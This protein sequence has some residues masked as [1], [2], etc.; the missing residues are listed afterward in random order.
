MTLL[1][2]SSYGTIWGERGG[3]RP[4]CP[5]RTGVVQKATAREKN[6]MGCIGQVHC[7]MDTTI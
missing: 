4:C 3:N 6:K 5:L 1:I 7:P 2:Y